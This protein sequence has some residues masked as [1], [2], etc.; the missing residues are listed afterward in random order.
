M[1]INHRFWQI[2]QLSAFMRMQAMCFALFISGYNKHV[3]VFTK[4][5]KEYKKSCQ[6]MEI[7]ALKAS[8]RKI[9]RC[10]LPPTSCCKPRL[11]AP[12]RC[13]T[14]SRRSPVPDLTRSPHPPAAVSGPKPWRR[15]LGGSGRTEPLTLC[16]SDLITS[17]DLQ[18][19]NEMNKKMFGQLARC[20]Q[21]RVLKPHQLTNA[22]KDSEEEVSSW[23]EGHT[24]T[25]WFQ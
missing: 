15:A 6:N 9:G 5:W 20:V 16:W 23:H 3:K 13:Q 12:D 8:K 2:R 14:D 18:F 19:P 21:L 24:L 1:Q 4:L 11:P 7:K 22:S 17:V 10:I 25:C